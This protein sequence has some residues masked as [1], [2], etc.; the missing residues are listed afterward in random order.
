MFRTATMIK[1]EIPK[2][3]LLAVSNS[4][5]DKGLSFSDDSAS[6]LKPFVDWYK[7]QNKYGRYRIRKGFSDL[8]AKGFIE[9]SEGENSQ[10]KVLLTE[11]GKR[12]VL[13]YKTE[14]MKLVPLPG[15]DRKWRMVV[16]N[17]SDP[18]TKIILKNKFKKLG[19]HPLQSNVWIYPHP[20]FSE[21]RNITESLNISPEV[22]FIETTFLDNDSDIKNIFG[23][24]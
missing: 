17:C 9:M 13:R 23:I 11:V 15:W 12:E 3:L 4:E 16:A 2:K 10:T 8:R 6:G 1:G 22:K 18:K 5:S 7:S 21:V 24:A 19:L 20:C 14:T